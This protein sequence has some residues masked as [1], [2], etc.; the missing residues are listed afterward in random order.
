[1]QDIEK[2]TRDSL[3]VFRNLDFIE[4]PLKG[5]KELIPVLL[6]NKAD[7]LLSQKELSSNY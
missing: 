5:N 3:S 4:I 2:V 7:E 1:M 6:N